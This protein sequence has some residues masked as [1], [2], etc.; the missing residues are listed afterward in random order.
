MSDI[1]GSCNFGFPN[2]KLPFYHLD[3][4]LKSV[5]QDFEI[6]EIIVNG[7]TIRDFFVYQD[8]KECYDNIICKSRPA[9]VIARVDWENE[10]SYTVE[11]Q[12][13]PT[14]SE[15]EVDLGSLTCKAPHHGG[16]WDKKWKYYASVVL[17]ENV[18]IPRHKE[19]VH[20]SLNFYKD[21]LKSPKEL[22]VVGIESDTGEA[23]AIPCQVIDY[24]EWDVPELIENDP[25]RYQSSVDFDIVFLADVQAHSNKVYLI[26]YGKHE[27]SEFEYTS[28]LKVSG[29][30]PGV[31]VENDYYRIKLHEKSG[32]IDEIYIK[33]GIDRKLDHHIE[34]PGTLHWNPGCYAPPQPWSHASDWNPPP[35]FDVINGSL[36]SMRKYWGQL[37]FG[38][39]QLSA[40][41]TYMFHAHKPYIIVST[42]L[43]AEEEISVK[44]LRNNTFVFK[45][46]LFDTFIWKNN[47]GEVTRLKVSDAPPL[48]R[49]LIR[50]SPEPLWMAFINC[51]QGYGFGGIPLKYLNEK[52][53]NG[54]AKTTQPY[55]YVAVGPW[56]SWSRALVNTFVTNNPQRL[57]SIP[58]GCLYF[59]R[60][61]YLSFRFDPRTGEAQQILDK[62]Q[63]I[64]TNPLEV[65]EVKM[66]TDKRV[67]RKWVP[68]KLSEAF[69]L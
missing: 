36:F 25:S 45:K 1:I 48:P 29:D 22:R 24:N 67:P 13:H 27:A 59:E 12:G 63:N 10:K 32:F 49:P 68:P 60:N 30:K 64:L 53:G 37:P 8:N 18:G 34:P 58:K 65:L 43:R 23:K 33:Q 21:R 14:R 51:D 57:V 26:F 35:S 6:T 66:D 15:G 54:L 9:R 40:S 62:Y 56:V 52:Y 7:N 42:V 3:V 28:D 11:I 4:L 17:S 39:D 61:A 38:I 2:T 69:D 46:Q 41:V 50:L 19:P 31:E 55:H 16:Y 47:N 5:E 20:L 44:A